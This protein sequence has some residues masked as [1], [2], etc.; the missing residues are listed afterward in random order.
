MPDQVYQHFYKILQYS[1]EE[2]QQT[3]LST[4]RYWPH[5]SYMLKKGRFFLEWGLGV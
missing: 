2:L 1:F 3:T 4:S 5:G